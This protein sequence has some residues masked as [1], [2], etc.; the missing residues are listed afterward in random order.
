M[1]MCEQI[2]INLENFS[3]K[4]SLLSLK[5][6]TILIKLRQ[7]TLFLFYE[8]YKQEIYHRHRSMHRIATAMTYTFQRIYVVSSQI[9]SRNPIMS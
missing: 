1:E 6:T 8:F 2:Q 5:F 4:H 7:L 3:Q 9:L